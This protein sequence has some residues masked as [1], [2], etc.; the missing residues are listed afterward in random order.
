M[1]HLSHFSYSL[2]SILS[3][4]VTFRASGNLLCI[5]AVTSQKFIDEPLISVA[6]VP[7]SPSAGKVKNEYGILKTRQTVTMGAEDRQMWYQPISSFAGSKE[8][9]ETQKIDQMIYESYVREETVSASEVLEMTEFDQLLDP[10]RINRFAYL[11]QSNNPVFALQVYKGSPKPRGSPFYDRTRERLPAVPNSDALYKWF[12]LY[13]FNLQS[14]PELPVES[15]FNIFLEGE[16]KVEIRRGAKSLALKNGSSDKN[17]AKGD[18]LNLHYLMEEAG[19]T[20][21]DAFR[22][23][24]TVYAACT[25]QML[26]WYM[27]E[28][29]FSVRAGTSFPN[30]LS[31]DLAK[32]ISPEFTLVNSRKKSKLGEIKDSNSTSGKRTRERFILKIDGAEWYA[33]NSRKRFQYEGRFI[34]FD[35]NPRRAWPMKKTPVTFTP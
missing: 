31:P 13:E 27:R 28:H 14:E 12:D 26:E 24:F 35:L 23:N 19:R 9:L 17:E 1:I 30:F 29:G 33:L 15:E 32:K 8:H 34:E 20:L 25:E 11:D 18:D 2:L 10:L 21:Q 7:I 6:Y 3:L 5:E 22:G 4:L 16:N